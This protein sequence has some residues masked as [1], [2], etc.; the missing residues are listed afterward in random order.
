MK[1]SQLS[2]IASGLSV[3]KIK[4]ENL[5]LNLIRKTIESFTGL[6][7]VGLDISSDSITIKA[8]KNGYYIN[9]SQMSDG[10]K[11]LLALVGD[12][13]R[14]LIQLNPDIE[15][16]LEGR[17]IVLIDEGDLHLHPNWQ[18]K[19]VPGLVKTFPNIQ[20][21]ITTHSP[22]ML[23]QIETGNVYKLNN[24]EGVIQTDLIEHVYGYDT[25][26]ILEEIMDDTHRPESL[27]VQFK[28][29]Y[30]KIDNGDYASA[31][32][33][34]GKFKQ[35]IGSDSELDRM[36]MILERKEAMK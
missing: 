32:S 30:S 27:K 24:V 28:L 18:R 8:Q 10:E 5:E 25:N 7:N 12:I 16:P 17:G 1:K 6:S 15:N 19:L 22:Q 26:R 20:F 11:G 35:K 4:N 36:M 21:I 2:R 34:I 29:I 9:S 33:D 3:E 31:R 23:S 14:R 13:T